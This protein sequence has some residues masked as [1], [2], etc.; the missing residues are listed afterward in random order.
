MGRLGELYYGFLPILHAIGAI[1]AVSL[2]YACDTGRAVQVARIPTVLPLPSGLSRDE[3][4]MAAYPWDEGG[5]F[6]TH[7]WNPFALIFVF[8]WLTA[9][10]ALR[11]L[12]YFVYDTQL[13]F[14]VWI[15]W[16]ILGVVLFLGWTFS[17]S[18]GVCVAMLFTVLAS[19]VMSAVVAF[20][21]LAS[22]AGFLAGGA[23]GNRKQ[24]AYH[25]VYS[26][27]EGRNWKIP[28]SVQGLS[29]RR[30]HAQLMDPVPEQAD[31]EGRAVDK[32]YERVWGV[33]VRYAEYCITA[34]LLFLAVTCLMVV[35]A[36]AWLFLTGYWLLVVCN[37]VGIAL[38]LSFTD[39][40]DD[41]T[42]SDRD[43][44][45]SFMLTAFFPGPW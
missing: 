18:G 42:V 31:D 15:L 16:L 43:D 24:V 30:A 35:D 28:S 34:P 12:K 3:A 44:W 40:L 39:T 20:E 33:V 23:T 10:F 32:E 41:K 17:N 7:N 27:R 25:N 13:L 5:E 37:A 11:P 19:F 45:L 6:I 4:F 1:L 14:R 29:N 2:S 38:H 9:G 8:E 26:D 22:T 21:S 36:P